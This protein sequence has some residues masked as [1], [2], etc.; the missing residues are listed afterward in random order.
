V[1]VEVEVEGREEVWRGERGG[2]A[3]ARE[4]RERAIWWWIGK[5]TERWEVVRCGCRVEL[6]NVDAVEYADA[7]ADTD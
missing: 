4:G 3:R 2:E 1:E 5:A 6:Q 7:D